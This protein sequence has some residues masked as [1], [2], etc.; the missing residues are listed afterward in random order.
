MTA[1]TYT[2]TRAGPSGTPAAGV[3]GF[4]RK[5][6][7]GMIEARTRQMELRILSFLIVRSDE[8]LAGLGYSASEIRDIR[9]RK[10]LPKPAGRNVI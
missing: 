7:N 3:S 5:M 4:F 10:R 6:Y 1:T 2:S 8:T 9:A